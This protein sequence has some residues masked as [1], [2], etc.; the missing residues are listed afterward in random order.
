MLIGTLPFGFALALTSPTSMKLKIHQVLVSTNPDCSSPVSV[1]TNNSPS[2]VNFLSSPTLGTGVVIPAT[3]QC[4]I[5]KMSDQ[6]KFIPAANDGNDC[7]A[8]TEYT[9]DLCNASGGAPDSSVSPTGAAIDCSA[10]ATGTVDNTV[11]I[12]VT[13]GSTWTTGP[14]NPFKQINAATCSASTCGLQLG[15]ALT[16]GG[17]KTSKFVVNGD[18]KIF[19]SGSKCEMSPPAM[20]FQIL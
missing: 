13:T 1:T 19:D 16:L 11:Y 2:F 15:S 10:D 7:V 20:S 9:L 8:G 4:I 18:N 3:Y 17:R 14:G 5:F 6:M 12:Y